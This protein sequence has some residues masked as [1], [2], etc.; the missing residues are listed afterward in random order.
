LNQFSVPA[1]RAPTVLCVPCGDPNW[2]HIT[3]LDDLPDQ[4][5]EEV[6]HFFVAYRRREG[7]DVAVIGWSSHGDAERVI[8]EAQERF[9]DNHPG[10]T[11]IP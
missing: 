6:A 8:R 1:A 10:A 11:P 2:Q 7:H 3:G 9:R 4:L 5:L